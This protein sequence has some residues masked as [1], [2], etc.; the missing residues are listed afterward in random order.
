MGSSGAMQRKIQSRSLSLTRLGPTSSSPSRVPSRRCCGHSNRV[1]NISEA[2]PFQI[3]LRSRL[4]TSSSF[5]KMSR[6]GLAW[7]PRFRVLVT[8]T[9]PRIP[10]QTGCFSSKVC[11]PLVVVVRITSMFA[12]QRT[13]Q[14]WTSAIGFARIQPMLPGMRR[15]NANLPNASLPTEKLTLRRRESLFSRYPCKLKRMDRVPPKS[16]EPTGGSRFCRSGF[17]SQRRLPPLAHAHR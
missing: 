8:S 9:G 5:S 14:S 3:S 7:S 4:L 1:L 16:I 11:R 13:S 10:A 6:F 12:R 2:R 17:L 15:S